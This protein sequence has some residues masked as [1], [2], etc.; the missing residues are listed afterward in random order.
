M[1]S[2]RMATVEDMPAVMELITEL[3]IFEKSA[4]QI[5]NTVEQLAEDGFGD[6]PLFE[7]ILAQD[8][9]TII[10]MS[11]YYFRYS[12]W[13]GKR[14]YLE[15]LIVTQSYR[16]RGTGRLLFEATIDKAK[17]QRCTGMVWQVLDWNQPAIEFYQTYTSDIDG[18][19]MNVKIN[20]SDSNS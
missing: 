8:D 5:T 9:D 2:I 11:L 20:F 4:D 18:Q 3:A 7:T 13:R 6:H 16:G 10:G 19:W 14:L 17:E 15:D 1:I 12:T